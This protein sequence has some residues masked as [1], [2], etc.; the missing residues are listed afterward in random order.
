MDHNIIL[1]LY[2]TVRTYKNST[3]KSLKCCVAW[4][5]SLHTHMYGHAHTHTHTHMY[6]YLLSI[7]ITCI[8]C[9]FNKSCVPSLSCYK[10]QTFDKIWLYC[11][12]SIQCVCDIII[13]DICK[14]L[15]LH[16]ESF[17]IWMSFL[18]ILWLSSQMS[19]KLFKNLR[20]ISTFTTSFIR[21]NAS[22]PNKYHLCNV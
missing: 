22:L 4:L 3:L 10:Y 5:W 14:L 16:K 17:C 12:I 13:S 7:Q 11:Q 6:I 2:F 15:I 19:R 21:N 18:Q 8:F 1:M 9:P 20:Y